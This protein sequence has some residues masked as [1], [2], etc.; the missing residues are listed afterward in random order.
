MAEPN[1]VSV[2]H[3]GKGFRICLNICGQ[4]ILLHSHEAETFVRLVKTALGL[5]RE[6]EKE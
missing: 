3:N 6:K 1:G 5:L 2:I 4:Q